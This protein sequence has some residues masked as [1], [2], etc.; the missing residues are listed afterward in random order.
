MN[1]QILQI[2]LWFSN[3]SKPHSIDF[4]KDKINVITGAKSTGKSSI[5]S[6]IDY[7]LLAT[8]SRIVEEI[9]NENVMWYG[10]LFE[11]NEKQFLIARK[12]PTGTSGSKEIYFDSE[13]I[14]PIEP[15]INNDIATVKK[16]LE[17]EFGI[18][19]TIVIPFGG[20][21]LKA[22]SKIS[23]RYFFLFNTLSED[24][25]ADTKVYFD[26]NLYD[27]DK[28]V[29]ALERIFYLAIGVDDVSNILVREKLTELEIELD[30]IQ[31]KKK[32]VSKEER[33]FNDKILELVIQAQQY[34]LLE[35]KLFTFEEGHDKLKELIN[36]FK[37][38][39]YS[40][41]FQELDELN[42]QKRTLWKKIRSLE[43]FDK[44]YDEYRAN[45]KTDYDSLK[46][47]AYLK[48]NFNELIPTLEVRSFIKMLDTS[49][50]KIKSELG[51]KKSI[52]VAV[53]GELQSLN[54][55]LRAVDLKLAS[56]PTNDQALTTEVQKLIFIGELKSQL[57]F[58]EDKWNVLEDMKDEAI[59]SEEISEL[60]KQLK[61][62]DVKRKL[63]VDILGEYIQKYYELGNSMG[64]Y[65]KYKVFYDI[66]DKIM[67]LRKPNE[68]TASANI[69]SKSNYMFLHLCLF[70]G[71]HEHFIN[72]GQNFV[73]TFLIMDQPSQ[74][75]LEN[76]P[77]NNE[78]EFSKNDDVVTIKDAFNLM[79]SFMS[80]MIDESKKHFQIILL[81]HASKSYW[82]VP[83][84]E[85]FHLV[86][87]FRDGNALI[88]DKAIPKVSPDDKIQ[89]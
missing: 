37:E 16:I 42:R 61:D 11:I 87:E 73:P 21:K 41:N 31:K 40:N 25:I 43:R 88:P 20:K 56:L 55:D 39:A 83:K 57:K 51:N 22:G 1:F 54:A 64:V 8:D 27:R 28:Y 9:I 71:L 69:G 52:S 3:G 77:A 33:L 82:E 24:T 44:E 86:Q 75:Y 36:S 46:P 12:K 5:L 45:L 72:H 62:T 48:E 4:Q 53:K 84:L 85:Y 79:N 76:S 19:D 49:L 80:N 50:G 29:E 34:D 35:R 26:F 7:C 60:K 2:V 6:I 47:V 18:D 15:F 74:P 66:S 58:Y 14:F 68:A 63:L 81:E 65:S 23:F 38:A 89:N 70:F 67:K 10:L 30:K 59:L 17:S 13:G 78:G 32:T